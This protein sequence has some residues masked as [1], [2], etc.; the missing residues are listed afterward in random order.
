MD[1]LDL[2]RT[3]GEPGFASSQSIATTSLGPAASA[4]L[5]R[6][7]IPT[8]GRET[9]SAP[10]VPP[11]NGLPRDRDLVGLKIS[12]GFTSNRISELTRGSI[13]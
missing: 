3:D 7:A 2:P 12:S 4:E 11:T 9:L 1:T 10:P 8:M 13:S 5:G 6:C